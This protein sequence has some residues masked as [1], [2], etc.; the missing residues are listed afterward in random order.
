MLRLLLVMPLAHPRMAVV[1]EDGVV[2]VAGDEADVVVEEEVIEG[3]IIMTV[4]PKGREKES[5][6]QQLRKAPRMLV[7]VR[8]GDGLSSRMVDLTS[9]Y[10]GMLLLRPFKARRKPSWTM[11]HLLLPRSR[12]K[13]NKRIVPNACIPLLLSPVLRLSTKKNGLN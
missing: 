11:G 9:G 5:S 6:W 13:Q 8:R 12:T 1:E 4:M 3:G 2:V 10:V 7:Q